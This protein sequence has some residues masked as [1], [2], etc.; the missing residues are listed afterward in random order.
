M[1]LYSRNVHIPSLKKSFLKI[2]YIS[3]TR[4]G[5]YQ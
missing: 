1:F 5:K 3:Y 4:Q 2:S